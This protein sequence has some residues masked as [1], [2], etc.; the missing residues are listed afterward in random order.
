MASTSMDTPRTSDSRTLFRH[1]PEATGDSPHGFWDVAVGLTS[2]VPYALP[3]GLKRPAYWCE[4]RER[5]QRDLG[6]QMSL[7]ARRWRVR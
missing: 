6:R 1:A 2:T 4:G 3:D 7:V 5:G